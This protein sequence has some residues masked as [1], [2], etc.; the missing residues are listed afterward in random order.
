MNQRLSARDRIPFR[1][2]SSSSLFRHPRHARWSCIAKVSYNS[3]ESALAAIRALEE[4]PLFGL[5]AYECPSCGKV[6][7]GHGDAYKAA[8]M[9][10]KDCE[11][12]VAR[13]AGAKGDALG[14]ARRMV[15]SAY[16]DVRSR[17][18]RMRAGVSGDRAE[19]LARSL[20]HLERVKVQAMVRLAAAK[21]Y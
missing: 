8:M 9:F 7:V 16:F 5:E 4:R 11:A 17:L 21:E 14:A 2:A 12:L 3:G 1:P 15:V 13:F 10:A 19:R 20:E 18:G 6:H